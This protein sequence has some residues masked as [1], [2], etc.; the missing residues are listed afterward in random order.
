MS[1]KRRERRAVRNHRRLHM[2]A[3]RFYDETV[4]RKD[5]QGINRTAKMV[6]EHEMVSAYVLGIKYHQQRIEE[7][8]V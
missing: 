1:A 4:E 3:D 6:G 2:L 8:A 7:F 5:Q